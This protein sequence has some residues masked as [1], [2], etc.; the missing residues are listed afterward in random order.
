MSFLALASAVAPER[1]SS[2]RTVSYAH[3]FDYVTRELERT[4]KC[5]GSRFD[6]LCVEPDC[7]LAA[8]TANGRE[9][10]DRLCVAAADHLSP[11]LWPRDA[12]AVLGG[13]RIGILF[14][15]QSI[16][17]S[18]SDFVDEIQRQLMSGFLHDDHEIRTTAS[19]GIARLTP[20][21]PQAAGVLDDGAAALARARREGRA[22]S[23]RFSQFVDRRFAEANE[24]GADVSGALERNEL[25]VYYQPIVSTETGRLD[26]FETL[27]RWRHP[28]GDIQ[29]PDE[30]LRSLEQ[31]GLMV[32]TGEWMVRTIASQSARWTEATGQ[33]IPLT[34]NLSGE[35]LRSESIIESLTSSVAASDQMSLLVEVKEEEILG[36]RESLVPILA[37]LRA[38]GV[39]VV[40]E[41]IGTAVCCL[42]YLAHMPIDAVK[43]DATFAESVSRYSSRDE[44]VGQIVELGHR[45]GLDVIG[46]RIERPEQMYDV[47]SVCDEM[48][49]YFISQPVDAE[50]ATAM[51]A[52]DWTIPIRPLATAGTLS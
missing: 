42:D 37:R 26:A 29:T 30:F 25:E 9:A 50:A 31:A 47:M 22:R 43:L 46:M 12:I 16:A 8:A 45:L 35:Q 3:F 36:D 38:S 49:G 4:R 18:T 19:I 6:F 14:D 1:H 2:P 5:L 41:G 27:L 11:L 20:G 33:T 17:R 10:A 39:R 44:I 34:I 7:Y 40:L 13:G 48:Q 28:A 23:I 21:Y 52:D 32:E 51:I 15:T 24:F